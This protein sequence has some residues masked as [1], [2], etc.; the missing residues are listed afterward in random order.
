[1]SEDGNGPAGID[2]W[3]QAVTWYDALRAA[4]ERDLTNAVGREWQDWYADVENR[5]VFDDVSL[6]LADRDVYRKR[7]RCSRA[8]IEGDSYDLSVPIADWRRV[9]AQRETQKKEASAGSWLWLSGAVLV[10]IVAAVFALWPQRFGLG[11]HVGRAVYETKVGELKDVRLADGS[12]VILGGR[13]ALSVEFSRRRRWVSVVEGQAWFRVARDPQRPFVVTAGDGTITDIGTA[14]LVTRESDRVVVTVMEGAVEVS[15]HSMRPSGSFD[16]G[17]GPNPPIAPIRVSRGEQVAFSNAGALGRLRQA[18]THTAVSWTQGRLT[19]DNQPLRYVIEAVSRYS[20][21]HIVVSPSAG[22]L[23][24][25]G[26]IL[27]DEIGDWL[28]SLSAVFPV[29][30]E[31]DGAIVRIKMR[32]SRPTTG[33]PLSPRIEP[34]LGS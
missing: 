5:R 3:F 12:S 10:T 14:F 28:Q 24:F 25:S 19:F 17:L 16:E 11:G 1:M 34:R 30:V 2:R 9:R 20:S 15:T 31:E 21:R 18:D 8:E 6:L 13:T 32:D 27:H 29:T 23:R 7:R 26:I 4:N 33:K 22:A